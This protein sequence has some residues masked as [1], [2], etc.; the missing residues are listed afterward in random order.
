M[1]SVYKNLVI[2]TFQLSS[3]ASLNLGRSQNGILGKGLINTSMIRDKNEDI[4]DG[5]DDDCSGVSG[6][7]VPAVVIDDG[8]D[9]CTVVV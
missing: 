4:D 7:A 3:A 8:D 5:D 6:R 2:T 1:Q 9:D